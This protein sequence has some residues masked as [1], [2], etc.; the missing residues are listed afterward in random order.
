MKSIE[1]VV[2]VG[3]R[4]M[5]DSGKVTWKNKKVRVVLVSYLVN[6]KAARQEAARSLLETLERMQRE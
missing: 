1:L 6:D 2:N 5:S 3:D 4:S